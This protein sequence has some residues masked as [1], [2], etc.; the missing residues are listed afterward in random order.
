MR[1]AFLI[2]ASLHRKPLRSGLTL[3]SIF[4]AF[5][6]FGLLQSLNKAF[7][8]SVDVAGVD[9]LI[10]APKYSIVDMLPVGYLSQ[11]EAIEGVRTVA[12]QTW[13]GGTYQDPSNF[14][15]QW[16]VP[17]K[18][19]M[20]IYPEL[21]L[22]D[23]ERNA[24]ISTRTG[25]IVGRSTADRF[26]WQVGD[27]IPLTSGI[28]ANAQSYHWEFDLVGI[29]DGVEENTDTSQFFINFDYF[30]EARAFGR[31]GVSNFVVKID[32]PDAAV[33]IAARIDEMFANSSAETK[34]STERAY[35][36]GFIKQVGDIGFIMSAILSAVFFTILLLTGTTM[37]QAV[38]ERVPELA[39]LKTIGYSDRGILSIV[40][41]ESTLLTLLGGGLGLA[42]ASLLVPGISN[43]MPSMMPAMI[44][45]PDTLVNGLLIAVILGLMVGF[46]PGLR[47]MRLSIIDALGEHTL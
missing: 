27:K 41:A 4:V 14:F 23:A 2:W 44:L 24:F 33:R 1:Y 47:A 36:L 16:P 32:D 39:I 25:V 19:Y 20:E 17:P 5:L 11:I 15:V 43:A 35:M 46:F 13:F 40:L 8:S 26:G 30:D 21:L 28:W 6:L 22:T 12:H 45:T 7:E 34:T 18:E 3:A 42:A 37:A 10:A 38:R 9:R 29:Y 31:G